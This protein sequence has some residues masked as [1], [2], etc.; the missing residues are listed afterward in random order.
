MIRNIAKATASEP[1][2]ETTIGRLPA[3]SQDGA[4]AASFLVPAFDA[5]NQEQFDYRQLHEL[6][7]VVR[8]LNVPNEE[9]APDWAKIALDWN[10]AGVP[11]DRLGVKEL[12]SRIR[13]AS[14]SIGGLPIDGNP[15]HWL[16]SLVLLV[17]E[18]E[19]DYN[20]GSLV[21]GL[22][23]DQHGQLRN[24]RD[25]RIDDSI[26]EEIKDIAQD[27]GIDLRSQLL[28]NDI[29]QALSRSGYES[30]RDLVSNLLGESF[31]TAEA[32]EKVLEWLDSRL[33][34]DG[35]L[36][37]PPSL[38][39]LRSSARLA[40]YLGSKEDTQ[41]LRRCPL[42]TAADTIVRL[43]GSQQVLAPVQHWS[44]EQQLYADL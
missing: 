26:P 21:D 40:L 38:P 12:T 22:V 8:G 36:E 29:W 27:A 31:S 15:F 35:T 3:L 16:A 32:V 10:Q 19:G 43:T 1:I 6:A 13:S 28:H 23:P 44:Q 34:S 17:A 18:L 7:T 33:P 24:A 9:I 39:L 25:L 14:G 11:V 42:L 20:P 41:R 37:E 2:I 5:D 30:A 4:G